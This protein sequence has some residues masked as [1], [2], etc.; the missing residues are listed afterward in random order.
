MSAKALKV[1]HFFTADNSAL[2]KVAN[3]STQFENFSAALAV[4]GHTGPEWDG[5]HCAVT[6][7]IIASLDSAWWFVDLNDTFTVYGVTVHSSSS[8]A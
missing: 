6:E 2:S 7:D 1:Y 8:K 5:G 3:Q 4:D